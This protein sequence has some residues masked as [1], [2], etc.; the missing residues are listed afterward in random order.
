MSGRELAEHFAP[1]RKD[2][3]VL[4]MSGYTDDAIVHH[5]V[6]DEG[7]AFIEKPFTPSAL[8]QKVWET[9]NTAVGV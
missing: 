6:L 2:M 8:T 5:G 4:F 1:L 9:L 3:K 7:T